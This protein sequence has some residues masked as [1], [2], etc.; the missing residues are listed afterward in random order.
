MT[1]IDASLENAAT[2]FVEGVQYTDAEQWHASAAKIRAEDPVHWL[3]HD[4]FNPFWV[5]S[6]HADVMN[7]ERHSNVEFLANPRGILTTKAGDAQR[8]A[9]GGHRIKSLV[10]MDGDEHKSIRDLAS[11]WFRPSNLRKMESRLDELTARA[12]AKLEAAD[13]E[14]DFATEVAMEYPL[15]VILA[16]MGLPESDYPRMLKLTQELFGAEDPEL[17]RNADDVAAGLEETV[18]EYFAYFTAITEDR[19]ANPTDDFCSVVANAEIDGEPIGVMEQ[20]GLYVILAT[21]GH[22]TTSHSMTGGLHAL[23]EH[24]EQLARLQADPGLLDSTV[25]EIVRWT[26]PVK[27]FMRTATCDYPLGGKTIRE[28]E[29]VFLSYWSANFDE[30]VFENP[31]SFDVGRKPNSQ[32]GFGF[33]AHYCLGAILA[34]MEIKNLFA[35]LA[36]RIKSIEL[37]D[38]AA[39]SRSAFVSGYK[40]LPIRYELT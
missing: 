37:A 8:E 27:H 31:W 23:I 13:G 4:D 2:A 40:H 17:G 28:G 25:D 15:Q 16:M 21:A 10:V 30:D 36:P 14:I 34:K 9:E 7:V 6:K 26:S 32:I 33:G 39:L 35:A 18:M 19:K 3:E 29:D 20:L 12:I 1:D 38:G 11:S 24:P 22:D 5:V